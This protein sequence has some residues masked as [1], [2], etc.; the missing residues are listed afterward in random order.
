[1]VAWSA[2]HKKHRLVLS[3]SI[4][5]GQAFC[6]LFVGCCN[7]S[8]KLNSVYCKVDL[9]IAVV[10]AGVAARSELTCDELSLVVVWGCPH[11]GSDIGIKVHCRSSHNP[12]GGYNGRDN[13]GDYCDP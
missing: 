11:P 12:D 8:N 9:P 13:N 7:V 2:K 5:D 10:V 6:S 4:F 3:K 1:M